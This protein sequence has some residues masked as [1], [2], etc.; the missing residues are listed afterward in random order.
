M[1]RYL[2]LL[3]AAGISTAQTTVYLRSGGPAA[4]IPT[5]A[6]RTVPFTVETCDP[7]TY[8]MCQP[9]GLTV[10]DTVVIQGL[11]ALVGGACV[12]STGNGIRLVKAVIDN[13]H[14]SITDLSGS[15]ITP[16]GAWCDGSGYLYALPPGTSTASSGM[17]GGK[18]TAY[19]LAAQPRA[20]LDGPTGVTTRKLALG[21]NNGLASLVVSG[22]TSA[23]R[24][25]FGVPAA[26][27]PRRRW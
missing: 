18:V 19:T 23:T 6:S 10:G 7:T 16:N 11:G 22:T 27:P 1:R 26:V 15:D 3:L 5:G 12:N 8:G 25:A 17:S 4:F 24:S 13:T 14:F 20:W 9:H 21:T 2:L